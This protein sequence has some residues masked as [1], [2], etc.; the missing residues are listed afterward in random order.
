[1]KKI[2]PILI[3]TLS[4]AS[5]AQALDQKIDHKTAPK[6]NWNIAPLVPSDDIDQ[7]LP[8]HRSI[9]LGP[10]IQIAILLDTSNSMDG[11]IAQA[12]S[13][14][15]SIVNELSD[16]NLDRKN[17]RIQVALMEYGNND[18]P[19]HKGY[20]R[21]VSHL[22]SDL[23]G[24]SEKLFSLDTNGGNEYAGRVINDSLKKLNWSTHEDDLRVIIIAGNES[25]KQGNIDYDYAI[26]RAV[27]KGIIVNT[28]FCGDRHQGINLSWQDGAEIGN[29]Y[30]L[31]IDHNRKVV[32]IPTPYDDELR[33]LNIKLNATYVGFGA[34]GDKMKQRQK[35]QDENTAAMSPAALS[36]RIQ[37]KA[38]RHYENEDWDLV[39]A[40][41]NGL[42]LSAIA[43]EALP[44]PMKKM[45]T[46]QRK[47]YI[48]QKSKERKDLQAEIKKLSEKRD[49]YIQENQT[50]KQENIFSQQLLKAVKS[51]AEAK[52]YAF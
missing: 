33:T 25:F 11:L 42:E 52:G 3:A 15:W 44:E 35:Q 48:E 41:K 19:Q 5:G 26:G 39:D 22:S 51:Q 45:E 32:D 10:T 38:S 27:G 31:N 24:V 2:L 50:V 14:I 34:E 49:S 13:K 28:I 47:A 43:E 12:K 4:L 21:L 18:N 8:E 46:S 29:G 6:I 9:R 23:D 20:V 7:T 1:M 17:A 37:S 16:A 36:D 40:S 30:Y